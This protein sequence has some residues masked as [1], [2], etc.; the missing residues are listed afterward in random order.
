M[1]TTSKTA[2]AFFVGVA[3]GAA[4]GIL[5]APEEGSKIRKKLKDGFDEKKD[6]LIK[7][8]DDLASG[9]KSKLE[10]PESKL[11]SAFEDV[12]QNADGKSNDIIDSLEKKLADLRSAASKMNG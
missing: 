4:L 12:A 5:F 3:V 2:A 7:R 11:Q 6:E 10:I 8:F 9:V 1:S